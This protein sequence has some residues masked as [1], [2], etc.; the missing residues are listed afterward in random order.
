V[1]EERDPGSA[2]AEAPTVRSLAT[3]SVRN[4]A[5]AGVALG[6]RLT[7]VH[8]PNGAGKSSL[9]EALCLALTARSPRTPR[10]REVI[11]FD[12]ALA[13]VEA[14]VARG[15]ERSRF[16]WSADRGGERRHLLDG[17]PA[18]PEASLVRPTLAVFVPDRLELVKGGPGPRRARVDRLAAT[19]WPARAGARERYRRALGQRNALLARARG[20]GAPS[21]LDAWD[22]ELAAAGIELARGRRQAIDRLAAEFAAAAADFGL[23]GEATIRY[24]PRSEATSVD[25]LAAELRAR[26]EADLGRGFSTLGPHLDEVELALAGRAVRRYASQGE[27]RA[28]LL[29]LLFAERRVLLDVR[30]EPPLMILDDVMSELDPDRRRLLAARVCEGA[31]QALITAT[32]ASHLADA[33]EREEIALRDGRVAPRAVRE[34]A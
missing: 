26:R 2:P 15:A 17:K 6:P 12:A 11:G 14:E 31:G 21:G 25:E 9:L 22:L 33:F 10:Q 34:A 29:A 8:G 16:L 30:G 24:R 28:T 4:L 7:L 18:G 5:D 13:R 27:Q 20:H 1:V 3:A 23:G 32:E 19:L